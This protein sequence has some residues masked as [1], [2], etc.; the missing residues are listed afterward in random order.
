MRGKLELLANCVR[1][2]DSRNCEIHFYGWLDQKQIACHFKDARALV[3][4]SLYECGGAVVLE[5][6][7]AGLPV[8]ATNWGGP[9]DYLDE[10]TGILIDP[11]SR[12][13]MVIDAAAA[14]KRLALDQTL[15][16]AIGERAMRKSREL[17][18]WREK[19]RWILE[20]YVQLVGTESSNTPQIGEVA[21]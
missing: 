3:L 8:I 13:Q 5:G 6:M 1:K 17:F 19:S 20:R 9:A 14:I 18:D 2:Q 21:E 16:L 15:T 12:E 11:I 4:L 10:T 7:A